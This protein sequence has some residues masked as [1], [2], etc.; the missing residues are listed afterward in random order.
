M[1]ASLI[2]HDGGI[3]DF[4]RSSMVGTLIDQQPVVDLPLDG[5]NIIGMVGILPGV[6][7]V[8]ASQTF[9]GDA[10]C[11]A[12]VIQFALKLPS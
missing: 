8:S 3:W 4:S 7:G 9:T 1:T 11:G 10:A 5:R 2:S 6:A 12:R